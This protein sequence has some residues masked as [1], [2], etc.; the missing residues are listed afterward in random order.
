MTSASRLYASISSVRRLHFCRGGFKTVQVFE[1]V[2]V[3]FKKLHEK[4]ACEIISLPAIKAPCDADPDSWVEVFQSGFDF[5]SGSS[6]LP[7]VEQAFQCSLQI[8]SPVSVHQTQPGVL[9]SSINA[10]G[11]RDRALILH[12]CSMRIRDPGE[13]PEYAS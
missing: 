5:F 3:R 4:I 13:S 11:S 6:T 10:S 12:L 7:G 8:T 2:Q 1:I 9:L